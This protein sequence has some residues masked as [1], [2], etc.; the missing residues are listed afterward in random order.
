MANLSSIQDAFGREIYDYWRGD[1][2]ACEIVERDDG[3]IDAGFGPKAYFAPFKDWPM[4][5]RKAIRLARGR[6]LD[7]GCGAG[8]CVLYLQEKGHRVVGIDISPLAIFV[9]RQRGAKKAVIRSVTQ[10]APD[11]GLFDTILMYGNNFGLFGSF[12][13]ARWLL[14]R[15]YHV[16]TQ[17]ARIIAGSTDPYR[18]T[19]PE[20]LAYHKR[21]RR[22][23]RMS[24]QLRL[25]IRYF[26][27]CTP[28]FDYLLASQD[29]VKQIL[30]GTG[31][32]I[33]RFFDS[34]GPM[35]CA[36]IEKA[37]K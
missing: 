13:R 4:H 30:D 19:L 37:G 25:R 27:Y 29:E 17:N 6:V 20:H 26:K 8:R 33:H 10:I 24:G 34:P 35:Y 23:G 21:N 18:T 11:L 3:Y 5:E 36:V 22:R 31:W 16:T 1:T 15:L 2:T 7:V 12:S 14:R 32:G 9:T 28:W